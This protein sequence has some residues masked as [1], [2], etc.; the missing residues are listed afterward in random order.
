MYTKLPWLKKIEYNY[1]EKFTGSLADSILQY[2]FFCGKFLYLAL[3]E[4]LK[5]NLPIFLQYTVRIAY[6]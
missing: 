4:A 3:F 6:F 5:C 1:E 2:I